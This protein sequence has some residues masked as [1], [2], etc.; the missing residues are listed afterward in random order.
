MTKH[1]FIKISGPSQGKAAETPQKGQRIRPESP[2]G[3]Q[4]LRK[5]AEKQRRAAQGPHDHKAPELARPAAQQKEEHT[6]AHRQA[7]GSVQK[8]GGPGRADPEGTQQIIQ[9]PGG[10]PEENGLPEHQKLPGRL[11]LHAQPN[12]RPRKPVRPEPWSS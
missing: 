7:I 12:R 3:P 8:A 1:F 4:K 9:Q 11:D 2:Q 6:P 5:R 10:Q